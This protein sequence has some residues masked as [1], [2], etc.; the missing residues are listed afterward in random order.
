MMLRQKPQLRYLRIVPCHAVSAAASVGAKRTSTGRSAPH[1]PTQSLYYFTFWPVTSQPR[2][3]QP[4]HR[5]LPA[6]LF[7]IFFTK[8]LCFFSNLCIL[9]IFTILPLRVMIQTQS[10]RYFFN[11]RRPRYARFPAELPGTAGEQIN[12]FFIQ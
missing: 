12:L 11:D 8:F 4:A 1:N 10:D 6:H 5:L 9:F 3:P 7:V 2:C